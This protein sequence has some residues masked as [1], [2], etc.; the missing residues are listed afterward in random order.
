[1]RNI[2]AEVLASSKRYLE[3]QVKDGK[4]LQGEMDVRIKVLESLASSGD[5]DT[6]ATMTLGPFVLLLPETSS[7]APTGRARLIRKS[8]G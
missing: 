2:P 1:M 6:R 4:M 5:A 7:A 3:E 8:P